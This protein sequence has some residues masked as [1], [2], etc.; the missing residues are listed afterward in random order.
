M[1][2]QPDW[3][4]VPATSQLGAHRAAAYPFG[5]GEII[6]R[7]YPPRDEPL[8]AHMQAHPFGG[9]CTATLS[10]QASWQT[11]DRAKRI[12]AI[13]AAHA[14]EIAAEINALDDL[15]DNA[16]LVADEAIDRR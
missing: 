4:D 14:A 2:T 6:A 9:T 15:P 5:A 13:F 1:A 10:A 7:L 11:P 16:R 12:A 3:Q 8:P